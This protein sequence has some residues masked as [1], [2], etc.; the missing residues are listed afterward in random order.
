[1]LGEK[2]SCRRANHIVITTNPTNLSRD[3]VKVSD[4]GS[5]EKKNSKNFH[6]SIDFCTVIFMNSSNVSPRR[7]RFHGT[8]G[9]KRELHNTSI[10]RRQLGNF[11]D[12]LAVNLRTEEAWEMMNLK[13]PLGPTDNSINHSSKNIHG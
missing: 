3:V 13:I 11:F 12:C 8:Y 10:F 4:W 2:H 9:V 7:A 1:L 5:I 6:I